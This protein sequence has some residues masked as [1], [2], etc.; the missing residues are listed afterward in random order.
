MG[1]L[2]DS[3]RVRKGELQHIILDAV[4]ISGVLGVGMLAPNVVG[5]MSKLG[6]IPNPRQKEYIASSASRLVK[7]GLLRFNGR[8][9]ELTPTGQAILREWEFANHKIAKPKKW[10]GKWRLV[11]FDIPEKKKKVRRRISALLG[12]AGFEMLQKSVWV[13]PYNCEDIIGLL[14]TDFGVGKNVLYLIVDEIENDKDLRR[15]FSLS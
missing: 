11:I 7:R 6:L 2:E 8:Y 13:F 1:I 5:A 12:Q 14:K 15:K 10:D 4:K 9:Y 3:V